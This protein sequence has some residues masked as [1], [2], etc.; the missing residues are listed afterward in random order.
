M[1]H[2][3]TETKLIDPRIRKCYIEEFYIVKVAAAPGTRRTGLS[4][5][6]LVF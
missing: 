6:E 4:F 5:N 2:V 1:K 3:P